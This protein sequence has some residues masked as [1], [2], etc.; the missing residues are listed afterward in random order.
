MP[1]LVQVPL[2]STG[3]LICLPGIYL[4][5]LGRVCNT[6]TWYRDTQFS[7]DVMSGRISIVD[8]SGA[9]QNELT[10][11]LSALSFDRT[12]LVTP[13]AMYLTL[14]RDVS[15]CIALQKR[16]FPH[17]DLDHIPESIQVGWYD[18]LSLGI[19]VIDWGCVASTGTCV[20]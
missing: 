5:Y 7:V 9:P 2:S 8:L 19:Y 20:T 13:V 4:G 14:P 15:S 17:L 16:I 10:T 3:R 6:F 18:G 12:Y 1:L 11:V